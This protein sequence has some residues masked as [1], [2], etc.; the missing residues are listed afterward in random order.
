MFGCGAVVKNSR[1]SLSADASAKMRK[2][3]PRARSGDK[4]I[5]EFKFKKDGSAKPKNKFFGWLRIWN[6]ICKCSVIVEYNIT[7]RIIIL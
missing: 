4:P 1:E 5:D 6:I 7:N 3:R 2:A